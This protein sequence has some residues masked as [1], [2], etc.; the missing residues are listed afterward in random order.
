M[1]AGVDLVHVP[2]RGDYMSDLLGGRVQVAFNRSV[3][4]NRIHQGW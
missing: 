4:N 1:M 2:Y 3:Y